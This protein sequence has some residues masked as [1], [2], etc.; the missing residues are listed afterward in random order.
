MG[1]SKSQ[2][3][4]PAFF[5][6][7]QGN[8]FGVRKLFSGKFRHLSGFLFCIIPICDQKEDTIS[9]TQSEKRGVA[10]I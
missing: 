7:A 5:C 2:N 4:R 8:S 3:N 10:G 1:E 6:I 9:V